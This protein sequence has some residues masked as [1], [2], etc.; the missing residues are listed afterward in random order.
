MGDFAAPHGSDLVCRQ[1]DYGHRLS[2]QRD[3]LD[4]VAGRIMH[5]H[6]RAQIAARKTV[7]GKINCKHD[8]IEFFQH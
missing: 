5:K 2:V 7:V 1:R 3:K 6:N 8:G 4:L